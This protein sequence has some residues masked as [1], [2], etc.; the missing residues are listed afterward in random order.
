MT[1]TTPCGGSH[2]SGVPKVT[3][4]EEELMREQYEEIL[5]K[6]SNKSSNQPSIHLKHADQ[7]KPL[8][9]G[10]RGKLYNKPFNVYPP[11]YFD[12]CKACAAHWRVNNE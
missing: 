6:S 12:V 11:G 8:C 3:E 2:V 9:T 10:I 1:A 5:V 4:K 7:E